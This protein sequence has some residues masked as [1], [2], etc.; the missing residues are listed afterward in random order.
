VPPA[1][2]GDPALLA[3]SRLRCVRDLK[4][5]ITALDFAT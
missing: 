4:P 1:R 5:M 3:A 2:A